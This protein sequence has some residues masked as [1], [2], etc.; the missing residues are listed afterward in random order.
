MYRCVKCG[1]ISTSKQVFIYPERN[2]HLSTYT[3]CPNCGHWD[4]EWMNAP[5]KVIKP[6][7]QVRQYF[8][9]D[10]TLKFFDKYGNCTNQIQEF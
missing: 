2:D 8:H 3:E 9:K 5:K 10:G 1:K 6:S 4:M 7:K